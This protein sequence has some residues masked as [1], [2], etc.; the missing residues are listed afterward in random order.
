MT[1]SPNQQTLPA[2]CWH[3]AR[4]LSLEARFWNSNL[5]RRHELLRAAGALAFAGR[6]AL[7]HPDL[8]LDTLVAN[9]EIFIEAVTARLLD[10]IIDPQPTDDEDWFLQQFI[11]I[12]IKYNL[13]LDADTLGKDQ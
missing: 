4:A 13:T 5:E 3:L 2:R 6:D 10:P 1:T 8:A 11:D 7:E 9:E 12:T